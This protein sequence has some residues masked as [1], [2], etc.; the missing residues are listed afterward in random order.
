MKNAKR[1]KAFQK[2]RKASLFLSLGK[3]SEAGGNIKAK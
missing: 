2:Q 1:I 3:A